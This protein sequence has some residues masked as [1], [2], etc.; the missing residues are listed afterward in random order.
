MSLQNPSGNE[1]IKI[2]LNT[3]LFTFTFYFAKDSIFIRGNKY[4]FKR[5]YCENYY[6]I[7]IQ[8]SLQ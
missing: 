6:A 5:V 8:I 1:N 3:Y 7:L 2:F 4:I